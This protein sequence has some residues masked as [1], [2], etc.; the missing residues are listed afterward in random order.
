MQA[1]SK[2]YMNSRVV[3]YQKR[4]SEYCDLIQELIQ[5]LEWLRSEGKDTTEITQRLE[6]ILEEFVRFRRQMRGQADISSEGKP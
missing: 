4:Q 2:G 5:E 1:Y 6:T 3:E